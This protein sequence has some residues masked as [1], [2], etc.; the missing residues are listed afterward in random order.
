MIISLQSNNPNFSWLIGKN[1]TALPLGK[2]IRNGASFGWYETDNI[3]MVTFIEGMYSNGK[4]SFPKNHN[5]DFGYMYASEYCDPLIPLT[6]ITE[7]FRDAMLK[8]SEKDLKYEQSITITSLRLSNI[9]YRLIDYFGLQYEIKECEKWSKYVVIKFTTSNTLSTLLSKVSLLLLFLALDEGA[10]INYNYNMIEKYINVMNNCGM[11]YYP[12][13]MLKIKTIH[14][15]SANADRLLKLLCTDEIKLSSGDTHYAR[16]KFTQNN[17]IEDGVIMDVGCGELR[18]MR[19]LIKN[20][21]KYIGVER[22]E[23]IFD[24]AKRKVER[25]YN[26]KEIYLYSDF[27]QIPTQ[28]ID[29][30]ILSEVIEHMEYD[31]AV[32][33]VRQYISSFRPERVIITTPNVD[34]NKNYLIQSEN[35]LRHVD[36]KFELNKKQ[37]ECFLMDVIIG[38]EYLNEIYNV[39]DVVGIDSCTLG[40]ILNR[41]EM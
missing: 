9:F 14:G 31:E 8:V 32:G 19:R 11:P 3:Y 17:A 26:G 28:K 6:L 10:T 34:F 23:E 27:S 30:L 38:F 37:F 41:S 40:A 5:E 24:T 33:T 7:Y 36:H 2:S 29:T 12:R 1:P 18:H 22:N 16:M 39:G 35:G 25:D 21:K 15:N 20:C 4:N 13:F